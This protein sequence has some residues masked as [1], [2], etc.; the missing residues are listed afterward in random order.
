MTGMPRDEYNR[1]VIR[2][3]YFHTDALAKP[4]RW[5]YSNG[6]VWMT[7]TRG[8]PARLDH[9]IEPD[10]AVHPYVVCPER[11]CPFHDWVRLEDWAGGRVE[12]HEEEL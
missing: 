5:W 6:E 8:H 7:C 2:R 9:G 10:G 12:P 3:V 11:G 1:L 4:T